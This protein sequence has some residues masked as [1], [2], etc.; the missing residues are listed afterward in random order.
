[1]CMRASRA[2]TGSRTCSRTISKFGVMSPERTRSIGMECRMTISIKTA[3]DA[4]GLTAGQLF[5]DGQWGPAADGRTWSHAHPATGEEVGEFAVAGVE[6]VDR[7]VRAARRAF[8]EGPWPRTRAKERIRVLRR[9]A[10]LIREHADELL[11]LQAL[12]NSVPLSFGFVYA[13]SAE[14]AADIFDHHAGWI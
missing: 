6:D 9:A 5:V 13:M 4:V 1:M 8:D 10:D 12:D 11:R 7:A 3:R 14:C 2:A